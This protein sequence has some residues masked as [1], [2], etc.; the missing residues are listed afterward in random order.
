MFFVIRYNIMNAA[1]VFNI[2]NIESHEHVFSIKNNY[3]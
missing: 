3:V 2:A 1:L